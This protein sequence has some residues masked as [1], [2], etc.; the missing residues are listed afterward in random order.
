VRAELPVTKQP[1]SYPAPIVLVHGLI[2]TLQ[3]DDL[4]AALLPAKSLSPD[5]LGYGVNDKVDPSG[6]TIVGQA[7]HLHR[8]IHAIFGAEPIH[9][10]GFSAG[11][12]VSLALAEFYP[13]MIASLVL[14]ESNF[15]L[16]DAA[17]SATI[18]AKS[19]AETDAVLEGF[20]SRPETWLARFGVQPTAA[21]LAK[22][23]DW[24]LRQTG[25]TV[26]AMAQALVETTG[27]PSY[28][29]MTAK[30]FDQVPVH[31]VAG[32]RSLRNWDLPDWTKAKA[33]SFTVLPGLGHIM[34]LEDPTAFGRVVH[35]IT[36]DREIVATW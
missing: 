24:L 13:E 9:L 10:V 33:R 32:E 29:H 26:R 1:S 30:V 27:K 28:L 5:L 15:T 22:A 8:Q 18:A 35:R 36:A 25:G 17:W 6:I 23:N 4:H 11:G 19:P 16:K 7:T 20:R 34:M 14:V 21:N 31:L 12:V 3:A 2:G